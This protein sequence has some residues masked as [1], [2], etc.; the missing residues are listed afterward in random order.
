[1][2]HELVQL[3]YSRLMGGGKWE[4]GSGQL[5]LTHAATDSGQHCNN[6]HTMDSG[7]TLTGTRCGTSVSK[8]V[9]L[10]TME[11]SPNQDSFQLPTMDEFRAWAEPRLKSGEEICLDARDGVETPFMLALYKTYLN[12]R[13]K[14]RSSE[15]Y[16]SESAD[17][18]LKTD[19][20]REY[21][22]SRTPER[23]AAQTPK[24]QETRDSERRWT[25]IARNLARLNDNQTK[26]FQILRRELDLAVSDGHAT[27]EVA[28]RI[29]KTAEAMLWNQTQFQGDVMELLLRIEEKLD[30]LISA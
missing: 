10:T 2:D 14:Q 22:A 26:Q 17:R 19:S 8:S 15:P 28:D 16:R 3:N 20:E 9:P 30:R 29:L 11:K 6:V 21:W 5:L 7:W 18:S 24:K 13:L 23:K 27:H 12:E 25:G 4:V 1:M